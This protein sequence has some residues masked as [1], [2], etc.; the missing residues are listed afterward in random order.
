MQNLPNEIIC[1]IS[2]YLKPKD[3]VSLS[4]TCK[5]FKDILSKEVNE[6]SKIVEVIKNTYYHVVSIIMEVDVIYDYYIYNIEEAMDFLRYK[7][8]NHELLDRYIKDIEPVTVILKPSVYDQRLDKF[9]ETGESRKMSFDSF[10][11]YVNRRFIDFY[12]YWREITDQAYNR[13]KVMKIVN[14]L[15]RKY[16]KCGASKTIMLLKIYVDNLDVGNCIKVRRVINI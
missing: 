11:Y 15:L 8:R 1:E 4:S 10:L 16:K 2:N 6:Y 3:L 14:R 9:V 12:E 13:N 5:E 7:Y